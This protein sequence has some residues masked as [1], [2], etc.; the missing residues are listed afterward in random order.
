MGD[1]SLLIF[2]TLINGSL[3]I[4]GDS[5]LSRFV[6]PVNVSLIIMEDISLLRFS[7]FNGC[8]S[9]HYGR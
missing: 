2:V 5:S 4:M 3:V 9:R 1:S 6:T 7:F 8:Q